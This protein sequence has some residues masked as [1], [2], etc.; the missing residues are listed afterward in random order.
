M[1]FLIQ[2]LISALCLYLISI[3][4]PGIALRGGLVNAM[5]AAAV[6]GFLN[7]TLGLLLKLVTLP[8][9]ILTLGLFFLVINAVI[10]EVA[11]N[12]LPHILYVRNFVS[13]FLGAAVLS[14]LHMAFGALQDR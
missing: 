7:V 12:L 13:A 1:R 3:F 14:L 8:L 6:V 4:V 2:W 9:G 5:I 11:S 10:L